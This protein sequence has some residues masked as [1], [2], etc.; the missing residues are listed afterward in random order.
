MPRQR[1]KREDR[2]P[3]WI[4]EMALAAL[5]LA[6]FYLW[7]LPRLLDWQALFGR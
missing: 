5:A 6:V 2:P 3:V 4:M 7:E 1:L